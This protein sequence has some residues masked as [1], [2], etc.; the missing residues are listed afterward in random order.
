VAADKLELSRP[1]ARGLA[2]EG[3]LPPPWVPRGPVTRAQVL[4]W[5]AHETGPWIPA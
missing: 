1:A 4:R 3:A 2:A 5:R